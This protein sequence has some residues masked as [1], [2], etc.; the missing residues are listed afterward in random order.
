MIISGTLH[1]LVSQSI[2]LVSIDFYDYMDN[3]SAAGQDWLR[4][5]ASL[6]VGDSLRI[7]TCGHSPIAIISVLIIGSLMLIA[8]VGVGY[9]PYRRE[10]PLAGSCSMAISAVCHSDQAIYDDSSSQ[11]L[12]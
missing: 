9:V 4:R 3:C 10:M 5:V 1:W 6:P 2:F 8:L 11:K 7:T 12:Q